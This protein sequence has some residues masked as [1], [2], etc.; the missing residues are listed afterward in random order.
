MKISRAP[1]KLR[2]V[3]GH[4]HVLSA[5]NETVIGF[6]TYGGSCRHF[7]DARLI[8]CAPELYSI[9]NNIIDSVATLQDGSECCQKSDFKDARDILKKARGV[10]YD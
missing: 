7:H 5:D 1:W 6:S 3:M 10:I 8:S 9:L 2:E 4:S